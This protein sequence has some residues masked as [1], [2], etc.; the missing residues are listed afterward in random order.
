MEEVF[1]P[2]VEFS[3]RFRNKPVAAIPVLKIKLRETIKLEGHGIRNFV[4][5]DRAA[6]DK[7]P[8]S[9]RP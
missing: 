2:T 6:V 4:N 3:C 8:E 5:L 7:K 9:R 1:M